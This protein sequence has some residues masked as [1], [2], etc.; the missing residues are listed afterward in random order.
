MSFIGF[1]NGLKPLPV[2]ETVA[3]ADISATA[4]YTVGKPGVKCE[5]TSFAVMATGAIAA[6]ADNYY[7]IS[8]KKGATKAGTLTTVAIVHTDTAAVSAN[9]SDSVAVSYAASG[10]FVD[11]DFLPGTITTNRDDRRLA[12]TDQLFAVF[13]KTASAA[14]LVAPVKVRYTIVT[15]DYTPTDTPS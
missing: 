4:T 7:V 8:L 1:G 14:N 15:G 6:H 11:G 3:T 12:A 9:D 5:V 2:I 10:S 13:T